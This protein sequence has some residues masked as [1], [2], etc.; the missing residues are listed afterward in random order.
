MVCVETDPLEALTDSR[1]AVEANKHTKID[2]PP[3]A[4]LKALEQILD[5]A[6]RRKLLVQM[7][8]IHPIGLRRCSTRCAAASSI[9]RVRQAGT[10]RRQPRR[11]APSG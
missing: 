11:S 1:M 3:G 4:D 10:R 8:Y 6:Q 7:G 2:K 5:E 9:L